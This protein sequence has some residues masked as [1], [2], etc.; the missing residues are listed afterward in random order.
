MLVGH[1]FLKCER[2]HFHAPFFGDL[3][4]FSVGLIFLSLY[5][6]LLF[7]GT[8]K[9][10]SPTEKVPRSPMLTSPWKIAQFYEQKSLTQ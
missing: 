2:F 4:N 10:I 7:I 3:G 9:K 6:Q 1:N 5:K 8:I